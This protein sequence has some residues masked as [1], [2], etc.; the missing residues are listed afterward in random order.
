MARQIKIDSREW[1]EIVN[2]NGDVTGGFYWNPS[3]LDIVKRCE[4]VMDFF[5][6]MEV[7]KKETGTDILFAL[8][9]TI[10]EQF[11]YLVSPGASEALFKHANPLS[12]RE[13]GSLYA[14]YVLGQIVAYIESELN[15]RI[16]KT[17]DK[18]KE[19]TKDYDK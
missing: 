15:V 7:P 18:I 4:K 13:N 14:E 12:P 2:S 3:D 17:T 5:E 9:D 10:K 16:R 1:V 11:D 6:H 8:S 19:Y